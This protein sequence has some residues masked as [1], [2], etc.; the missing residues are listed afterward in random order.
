MLDFLGSTRLAIRDKPIFRFFFV[1]SPAIVLCIV[2]V[3]NDYKEATDG[4][5]SA[6][7]Q[8]LL[9]SKH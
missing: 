4:C 2:A 7:G 9:E 3:V 5:I 8:D 1:M 6:R